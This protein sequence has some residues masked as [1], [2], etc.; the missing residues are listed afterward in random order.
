MIGVS[1]QYFKNGLAPINLLSYQFGSG[2]FHHPL[3]SCCVVPPVAKDAASSYSTLS[4]SKSFSH[5]FHLIL[6][7]CPRLLSKVL[8]SRG[9]AGNNPS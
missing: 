4:L 9:C 8:V 6:Q 1:L 7:D 2:E 5:S 3:S